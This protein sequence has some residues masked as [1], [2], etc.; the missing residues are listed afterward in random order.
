MGTMGTRI[1]CENTTMDGISMFDWSLNLEPILYS[2]RGATGTDWPGPLCDKHTCILYILSRHS[3]RQ[4]CFLQ[5]QRMI[6]LV[7]GDGN[8]EKRTSTS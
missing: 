2:E 6:P 1:I 5:V 3:E 4:D 7:V 8:V